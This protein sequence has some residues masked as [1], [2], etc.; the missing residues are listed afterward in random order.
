MGN[1]TLQCLK[2]ILRR[3]WTDEY[4]LERITEL[5]CPDWGH[6]NATLRDTLHSCEALRTEAL[7]HYQQNINMPTSL[8]LGR[9]KQCL[10]LSYLIFLYSRAPFAF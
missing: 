10:C 1:G 5:V 3:F 7:K 2:T 9:H 4:F 8:Q 6:W